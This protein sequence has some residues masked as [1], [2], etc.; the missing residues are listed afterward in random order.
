MAPDLIELSAQDQEVLKILIERGSYMN[1]YWNFYIAV[2]SAVVGIMASGKEF[3]SSP[4]LKTI[5]VLAFSGFAVSNYSALMSLVEKR[6]ALSSILSPDFPDD[7][8]DS[9]EPQ[10]AII[11]RAFHL[12]MVLIVVCCIL[13]VPWHR[14]KRAIQD[15]VS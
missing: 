11:Y 15:S 4:V 8:K 7:L 12:T 2:A 10:D 13:V 14:F 1:T 3:A 6:L 9:L 5:L